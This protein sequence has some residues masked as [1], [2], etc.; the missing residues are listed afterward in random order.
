MADEK[1]NLNKNVSKIFSI[2]HC[3]WNIVATF[4]SNIPKYFIAILQFQLSEIFL[5]KKKYLKVLEIL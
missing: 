2:Y 5:T 4:L 1:L 3:K